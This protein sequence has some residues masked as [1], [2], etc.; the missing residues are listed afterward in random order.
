MFLNVFHLIH[1][2]SLSCS[3]CFSKNDLSHG[4]LFQYPCVF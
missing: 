2:G 1:A 4:V 3:M